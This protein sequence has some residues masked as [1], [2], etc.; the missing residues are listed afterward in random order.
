MK[1]LLEIL[2]ALGIGFLLLEVYYFSGLYQYQMSDS[3]L[4]YFLIGIGIL[5]ILISLYFKKY[6][7]KGK[8]K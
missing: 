6:W 7:R 5:G 8:R 3:E 2:I 4:F 1:R